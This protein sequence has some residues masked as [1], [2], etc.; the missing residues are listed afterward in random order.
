MKGIPILLDRERHLR[1]TLNAMIQFEELT[2]KEFTKLKLSEMTIKDMRVLLWLCLLWE[3]S[4]LTEEE[5][6]AMIGLDNMAAVFD[7]VAQLTVPN[8]TPGPASHESSGPSQ[9]SISG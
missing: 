4:A 7:A 5:V 1:M 2:G 6:G 8:P 9:E 3:D